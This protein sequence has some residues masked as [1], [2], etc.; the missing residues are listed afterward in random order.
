MS[1]GIVR[2]ALAR[3]ERTVEG[4]MRALAGAPAG[5]VI[6]DALA[7]GPPG[8]VRVRVVTT[9]RELEEFCAWPATLYA[10]DPNY[11]QPLTSDLMNKLTPGRDPFWRNA[12]RELFLATRDGRTVGTLA[13]V[14][15]RGR[16]EA[17]K[18]ST[19]QFGWFECVDDERVAA[20]LIERAKTW[21]R[22]RGCEAIEGPYN[23]S[24]SDEHGLLIEGFETRPAL[25]EGHHRRY[26]A[27]L[28]EKCGLAPLREAYAWLVKPD[29]E[30]RGDVSKIFPEKLTKGAARARSNPD[31]RVRSM[32]LARWDDE[33][34]LAHELYNRSM[35]TVADFVPMDLGSFRQLCD[36]F[37]PIV[38]A[39]LIKLVEVKGQ[40]AG[41][42]LVLPDANQALRYARGAVTPLNALRVLRESQK[43]TRVCFK[44]L[45]IDPAFRSRGLESLLIEECTKT[46][47]AKGFT[48]A[49]LSLTGEENT[50]INFILFGLGFTIYRKY[51]TYRG[52]L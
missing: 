4:A 22:A 13:A 35:A 3:A 45:M 37:R 20:A 23:P 52:A 30:A 48:E 44:V 33:V 5:A 17:K 8:E 38:D 47:L 24:A 40:C 31:V 25:M 39:E 36:S 9:R 34:R 51:K 46:I 32:D 42:A 7:G 41:Y 19:G 2:R 50:K 14:L 43:L 11:V 18:D 12:E 6:A 27:A 26:Y 10:D 15:D 1:E 21:L 49:D 29:P 16:L 28:L